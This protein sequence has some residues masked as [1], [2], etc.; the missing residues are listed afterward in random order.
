M[1]RARALLAASLLALAA[2]ACSKVPE[3]CRTDPK[4]FA[5]REYRR[6]VALERRAA[7]ERE[8]AKRPAGDRSLAKK[9]KKAQPAEYK[10]GRVTRRRN[11][12]G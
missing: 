6:G 12:D 11:N 5:C 9:K 2:S 10:S 3:V 8:L 4:G 1:T 7:R